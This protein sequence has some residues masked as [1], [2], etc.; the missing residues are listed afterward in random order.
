M[1]R[2][3]D[4]SETLVEAERSLKESWKLGEPL[5]KAKSLEM[6][7]LKPFLSTF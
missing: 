4:Q 1:N 2:K 5:Q 3:S 7:M 6:V